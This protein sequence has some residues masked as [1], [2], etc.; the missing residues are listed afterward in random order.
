MS[1]FFKQAF[2]YISQKNATII[3]PS[4]FIRRNFFSDQLDD[5]NG[6][7]DFIFLSNLNTN[8][9]FTAHQQIERAIFYVENILPVEANIYF[10]CVG[11]VI[12]NQH[13]FPFSI[14]VENSDKII[15]LSS[16]VG[17]VICVNSIPE[18]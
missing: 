2:F 15:S 18:N 8:V 5:E 10:I 17:N 3:F 11:L 4:N 1:I 13:I 7:N 12:R 6:G 9:R 14:R 16:Q